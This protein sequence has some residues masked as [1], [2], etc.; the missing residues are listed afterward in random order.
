MRWQPLPIV[1][2]SYKDE[3]RGWTFQDCVN[4]I[5]VAAEVQGTRTP[6]LLRCAPGCGLFSSGA[7]AAPCRGL[8]NV[9]GVLFGVVG[10]TLYTWSTTGVATALGTVPGVER[11][12][13]A[14]NQVAGGNQLAI[15][16]NNAGYVYDTTKGTLTQIT[17]EGFPGALYF[18]FIDSYIVGVDPTRNF[19]FN[20]ALADAFTYN[21]LD[22]AQAEAQPDKITGLAVTHDELW[23]FGERTIQP[24]TDTGAAQA[25]FESSSNTVIEVGCAN[26]RTIC[27]LDNS[28]FWLGNDGI[29]Y[30]ANGYTPMRISTHPVEQAI[31][32]CD[33]NGAFAFVFESRGHKV[34]YLTFPDGNTW[35]YDAASN[36]WHRRESYGMDRWRMNDLVYWNGQWI[37]ADYVNGQLY[38]LDWDTQNEAGVTMERLRAIAPIVDADNP[39]IINGIDVIADSGQPSS[40]PVSMDIRYSRDA[41]HNWSDWRKMLLGKTGSFMQRLQ[42]RRFGRGR[43]WVF[44]FRVTDD[45]RADILGAAIMLEPCQS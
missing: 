31:S 9:E 4:M 24:F 30:R 35:G 1:G 33:F 34:Y 8:H 23:V 45:V 44:E 42:M 6:A 27:N 13:M 5:P 39:M 37:G 18:V 29:V 3:T 12:S 41:G 40:G 11:V 7:Q 22:R 38:L 17:S 14:H 26:G 25:P 16:A 10:A 15:A 20:S 36:E 43:Q 28:L 19:I 2:G 21:S 32:E